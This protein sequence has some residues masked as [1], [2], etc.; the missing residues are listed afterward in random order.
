MLQRGQ[1]ILND[2]QLRGFTVQLLIENDPDAVLRQLAAHPAIQAD[3]WI[4]PRLYPPAQP[5]PTWAVFMGRV[6]TLAEARALIGR[7]PPAWRRHGP[8][9]RSLVA[10]RQEP[11]PP[12]DAGD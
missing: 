7:L 3:A 10:L 12:A 4:L 5:R 9:I 8:Q 2:E 1:R 11:Q 6:D